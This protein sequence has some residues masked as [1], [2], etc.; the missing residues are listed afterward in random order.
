[1]STNLFPQPY[2][3]RCGKYNYD[4]TN[5]DDG[6]ENEHDDDGVMMTVILLNKLMYTISYHLMQ[7]IPP[8]R[9]PRPPHVYI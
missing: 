3:E 4:D 9:P 2:R 7:Q 6:D 1:M 5:Y 8:A